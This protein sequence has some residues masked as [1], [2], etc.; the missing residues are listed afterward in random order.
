MGILSKLFGHRQPVFDRLVELTGS[1]YCCF[2]NGVN[3]YGEMMWS[4]NPDN[5]DRILGQELYSY[6]KEDYPDFFKL[7]IGNYWDN[8]GDRTF[9]FHMIEIY[10]NE[11]MTIRHIHHMGCY[12]R[13]HN[14]FSC[15][16]KHVKVVGRLLKRL[17]VGD[18]LTTDIK[19][20]NDFMTKYIKTDRR[21]KHAVP[22]HIDGISDRHFDMAYESLERGESVYKS[23]HPQEITTT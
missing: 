7:S 20:L 21:Y 4:K 9:Q 23:K 5:P 2:W 10:V 12:D 3:Y 16:P 1:K 8:C 6:E 18:K 15:E 11:D 19:Q 13:A 14:C 17:K 22:V